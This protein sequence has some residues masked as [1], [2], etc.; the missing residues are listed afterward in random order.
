MIKKTIILLISIVGI[1]LYCFT[2]GRQ[3]N[4]N[5]VNVLASIL[6]VAV[7]YMS[8]RTIC[9]KKIPCK[10]IIFALIIGFIT[11]FYS[12]P[13]NYISVIATVTTSLAFLASRVLLS[14]EDVCIAWACKGIKK[15]VLLFCG[16]CLSYFLICVFKNYFSS[17]AFSYINIVL[18]MAPAISEELIF[19]VF[20]YIL[21]TRKFN[22]EESFRCN[23]WIFFVINTP[24][25]LLHCVQ[26][27]ILSDINLVI[28][29]LYTCMVTSLIATLLI[30]KFGVIYGIF[31]H[32]VSDF[33]AFCIMKSIGG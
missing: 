12:T 18:A 25:S 21:F 1:P 19:R 31:Q 26:A 24:F 10:D 32:A 29:Q 17:F 16:I 4:I 15:N 11:L 20:L 2:I 3:F 27:F 23:V 30:N 8:I 9:K 6:Y 7:S 22:E 13:P 28:T 5:H 33:L 14:G